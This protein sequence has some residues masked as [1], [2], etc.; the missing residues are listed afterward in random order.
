MQNTNKTLQTAVVGLSILALCL[1]SIIIFKEYTLRNERKSTI[2]MKDYL[3]EEKDSLSKELLYMRD[4][5]ENLETDND[6]LKLL[7]DAQKAK[8][9]KLLRMRQDAI[10]QVQLYKKEL[11]TLRDVLKDFVRQI[12]SLNTINIQLTAENKEVKQKIVAVEDAN[13]QLSDEKAELSSKVQK[14]E[15]LS[16][17]NIIGMGLNKRGKETDKVSRTEKLKV[18]FT[19]RENSIAKSGNR[20]VYL[21]I[22]KP[23]GAILTASQDNIMKLRKDESIYTDKR[24]IEYQNSDIDICIYYDNTPEE[25]TKGIY[26]ARLFSEGEQIGESTFNLD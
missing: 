17:K 26:T 11:G 9:D 4:Q 19:I 15:I 25:I 7:V 5:Y 24:E 14:A 21:Q 20:V 1:T 18:C 23:D 13:K 16:A 2:V 22:S 3:T 6:T 8:I 12:D 10:Y